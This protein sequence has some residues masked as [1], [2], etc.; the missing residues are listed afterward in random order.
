M[1]KN[2]TKNIIKLLSES[3]NNDNS[4]NQIKIE[5]DKI[6]TI[7]EYKYQ[8]K[9]FV[10]LYRVYFNT[11]TNQFT[12]LPNNKDIGY[13]THIS[14]N[15]KKRRVSYKTFD[16]YNDFKNK[17][18]YWVQNRIKELY[19]QELTNQQVV[20]K[21]SIEYSYGEY[22]SISDSYKLLLNNEIIQNNNSVDQYIDIIDNE[23]NPEYK[24]YLIKGL[25]DI[26][27]SYKIRKFSTLKK[28]ITNTDDLIEYISLNLRFI[29]EK[30]LSNLDFEI[31][32]DVSKILSTNLSCAMIK[33][34]KNLNP[35]DNYFLFIKMLPKWFKNKIIFNYSNYPLEWLMSENTESF[36]LSNLFTKYQ[37]KQDETRTIKS[38]IEFLIQNNQTIFITNEAI[39][40]FESKICFINKNKKN[41]KDYKEKVKRIKR[42]L[43]LI[44]SQKNNYVI[45][46]NNTIDQKYYL[47]QRK[48]VQ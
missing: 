27:N 47:I 33:E 8:Y 32:F 26:A 23:D 35:H 5:F 14:P 44:K 19:N 45:S 46:N 12:L 7:N 11:K 39:K 36:N 20:T 30:D 9:E 22:K 24:S 10:R 2:S 13:I 1:I 43:K 31:L 28:Y 25:N 21:F 15:T 4:F 42:F 34:S 3:I 37:K 41:I 48:S 6:N 29:D 38:D 40:E 18:I 16:N 17:I